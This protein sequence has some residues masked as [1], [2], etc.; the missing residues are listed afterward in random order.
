[1]REVADLVRDGICDIILIRSICLGGVLRQRGENVADRTL[2]QPLSLVM[3]PFLE[4]HDYYR[5]KI[6]NLKNSKYIFGTF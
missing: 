3:Y 4:L 5:T 2:S 1:M 6:R